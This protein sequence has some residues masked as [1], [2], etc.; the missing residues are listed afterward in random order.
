MTGSDEQTYVKQLQVKPADLTPKHA[1]APDFP[2]AREGWGMNGEQ[3]RLSELC[4][5]GKMFP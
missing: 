1:G 4:Q 2:R 3:I 5:V